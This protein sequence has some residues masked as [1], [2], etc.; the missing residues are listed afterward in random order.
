LDGVSEL[1]QFGR[2]RDDRRLQEGG[3]LAPSA[4]EVVFVLEV[5]AYVVVAQLE[6]RST[7]QRGSRLELLVGIGTGGEVNADDA[8]LPPPLAS[9][10]ALDLLDEAMLGECPQVVAARRGALP[11]FVRALGRRRVAL[12]LEVAENPQSGGMAERAQSRG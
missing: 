8:G 11:D 9:V 12:E 2:R 1:G 3:R 7:C 10:V 6:E 4:R 5:A